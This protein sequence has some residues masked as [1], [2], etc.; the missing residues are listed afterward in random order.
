ML[1]KALAKN[2]ADRFNSAAEFEGELLEVADQISAN[3]YN[4]QE[5]NTEQLKQLEI[6]EACNSET[7]HELANCLEIST[8]DSG[9][10]IFNECLL[11]E[12]LCLIEGK[13]LLVAEDRHLT[14][15]A[16]QWLSESI[17]S[18]EFAACSCKALTKSQVMRVS[19]SNILES[20]IATQAYFF[21]FILDRI[22]VQ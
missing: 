7:L 10:L 13:A 15:N 9:E 20:S 5:L 6:F 14:V 18:R 11:D 12:Y 17:L 3:E 19:K 1:V 8:V 4:Y 21:Q 16:R 2:P 22:F